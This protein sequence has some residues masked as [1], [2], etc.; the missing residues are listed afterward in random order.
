MLLNNTHFKRKF[1]I[2]NSFWLIRWMWGVNMLVIISSIILD[3]HT[4]TFSLSPWLIITMQFALLLFIYII[5]FLVGYWNTEK[6]RWEV[7]PM[8]SILLIALFCL[9]LLAYYRDVFWGE[10]GIAPY[11]AP[12]CFS[13][14][15]LVATIISYLM[16]KKN[17]RLSH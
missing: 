10:H 1:R 5:T 13:A 14:A 12:L 17:E 9:T 2:V 7:D 3:V 11:I 8:I 6:R 16:D 4:N 15:L